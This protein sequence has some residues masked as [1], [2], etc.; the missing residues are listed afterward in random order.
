MPHRLTDRWELL[1]RWLPQ[2]TVEVD[3]MPFL[4]R[5]SY[6]G[7]F[8]GYYSALSNLGAAYVRFAPWVSRASSRHCASQMTPLPPEPPRAPSAVPEPPCRR[9]RAAAERLH[10][11]QAGHELEQHHVR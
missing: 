5:T 2:A 6:G 11:I 7:P 3:V 4:G 9:H 1:A 8:D 10:R